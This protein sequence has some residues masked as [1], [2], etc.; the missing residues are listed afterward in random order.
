MGNNGMS[1]HKSLAMPDLSCC[2]WSYTSKGYCRIKEY[3]KKEDH[4]GRSQVTQTSNE[5]ISFSL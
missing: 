4:D 5:E 1:L 2:I 3:L